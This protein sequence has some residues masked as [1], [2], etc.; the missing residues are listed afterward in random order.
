MR[1][2]VILNLDSIRTIWNKEEMTL[3]ML[4]CWSLW[5]V[6]ND[7]T[8]NDREANRVSVVRTLKSEIEELKRREKERD[9]FYAAKRA[10]MEQFK[11]KSRGFVLDTREQVQQLRDS[12]SKLKSTLQF[13]Q[14]NGGYLNYAEITAEEARKFEL[15]AEKEKLDKNLA[16]TYQYRT[17][18]QKQL[19]KM[20]VSKN[21][22]EE[23]TTSVDHEA[24]K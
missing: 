5:T 4:W 14:G 15:L 20:L 2:S 9:R 12:V 7:S 8:F 10:E 19:Q 21:R 23:S 11:E 1:F 17:L 24:G 18:L 13:L 3:A 22:R 16:S 6:K